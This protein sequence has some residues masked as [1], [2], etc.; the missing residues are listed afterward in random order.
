MMPP[1]LISKLISKILTFSMK[2]LRACHLHLR[3]KNFLILES[4]AEKI[5]IFW[6]SKGKKGLKLDSSKALVPSKRSLESL[7]S[8]GKNKVKVLFLMSKDSLH[9]H[10]L[11]DYF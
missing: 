3:I 10:E 1:N 4:L 6:G 5:K 9:F 11:P 2:K 8:K 7:E